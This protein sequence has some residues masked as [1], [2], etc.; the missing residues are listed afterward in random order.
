MCMH[1]FGSRY[2][3]DPK[4]AGF[5]SALAITILACASGTGQQTVNR[6]R[7]FGPNDCGPVDPGYIR[8]ANETGGQ[9][10]FLQV[11]EAGKAAQ[12][13]RE[14]MGENGVRSEERR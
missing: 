9:P 4:S 14:S 3:L 5:L 8:L 7:H 6:S 11:S 1:P 13:M 2:A 12:F 10:M